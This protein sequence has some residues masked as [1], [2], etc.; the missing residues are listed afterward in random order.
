MVPVAEFGP[1]E[2]KSPVVRRCGVQHESLY[3]FGM[4]GMLNRF[5]QEGAH[6]LAAVRL[7][8]RHID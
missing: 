1:V 3:T 6:P 2:V 4:G 8:Y 5:H 7:Q